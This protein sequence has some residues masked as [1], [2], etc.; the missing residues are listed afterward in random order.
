V[1]DLEHEL[2]NTETRLAALR[3][4]LEEAESALERIMEYAYT[5]AAARDV[6]PTE[7]PQFVAATRILG[8][9]E[10]L[11]ESERDAA[12]AVGMFKTVFGSFQ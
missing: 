5:G 10:L 1:T 4:L 12:R 8:R 2:R 3:T 11:R 9:L 6:D 7:Q